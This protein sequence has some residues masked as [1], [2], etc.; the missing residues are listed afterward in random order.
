MLQVVQT[1]NSVALSGSVQLPHGA[2]RSLHPSGQR[3]Q[4]IVKGRHLPRIHNYFPSGEE[5]VSVPVDN[6]SFGR[7]QIASPRCARHT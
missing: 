2:K 1:L 3:G 5:S 6:Y 4:E 7:R